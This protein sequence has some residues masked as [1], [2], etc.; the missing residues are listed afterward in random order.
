[1]YHLFRYIRLKEKM[2]EDKK[3]INRLTNIIADK[4]TNYHRLEL[5]LR[6]YE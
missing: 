2:E 6:E 5:D 4:V 3:I 1:M